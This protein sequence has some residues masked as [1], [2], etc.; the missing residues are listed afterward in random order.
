MYFKW[1]AENKNTGTIQVGY[2]YHGQRKVIGV[3]TRTKTGVTGKIEFDD[4]TAS[5]MA[6]KTAGDLKKQLQ[7]HYSNYQQGYV[8][9]VNCV[10]QKKVQL[11]RGQLGGVCDPSTESYH[12]F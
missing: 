11:Q 4:G 7:N 12:T 6:S 5:T 9:V 8:W 1:N 10:T 2:G 3:I